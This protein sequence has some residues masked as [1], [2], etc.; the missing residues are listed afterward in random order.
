[1]ER[2]QVG[3]IF[4]DYDGTL[5]PTT[6][7]RGGNSYDVGTIPHGLEQILFRISHHLPISIVSSKD[8][9]FLHKR[10]RFASI[11]SCVL[12]LETISHNP[13][14]N[15]VEN[16]NLGCVRSQHLITDSRSLQ[17]NSKLL[18]NILETLQTLNYTDIVIEEK[19]TSDKEILIGLT[20]D[21]RQIND[22]ISFKENVEPT[23]RETIQTSIDA[24][25]KSNLLRDRPFIQSYTSHSFLDVYGTNCDKGLAIDNILSYFE[26]KDRRGTKIMYLG[27]SENDNPA[28]RK[29]DI[30]IGIRSDERLNPNLDCKYMIDFY[31][32]PSF[33]KRLIDNGL[34]FSEELLA[35]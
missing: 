14:F 18:R 25:L 33:L 10:A 8:F 1:M 22:W 24:K 4:S 23:I 35:R 31:Q 29:S 19:Y 34:V 26:K 27:D 12:G 11:L 2:V 3:T 5:C 17:H 13:H 28:F 30:S 21:Y 6:S 7:A 15:D 32:L 9:K 16:K 20:V